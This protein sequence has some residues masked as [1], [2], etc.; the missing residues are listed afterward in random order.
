[1]RHH[2]GRAALLRDVAPEAGPA[3]VIAALKA[4]AADLSASGPHSAFSA[5]RSD[6][7]SAAKVFDFPLAVLSDVTADRRS[8]ILWRN[9]TTGTALVWQMNGFVKDSTGSA[10]RAP[11]GSCSDAV[12]ENRKHVAVC[13]DG[14]AR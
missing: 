5:G 8:D 9:A 7:L 1:M 6:A 13:V 2:P 3:E 12:C 11:S 10:R 14:P 4:G